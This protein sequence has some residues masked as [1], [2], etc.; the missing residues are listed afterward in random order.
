M[1]V[2]SLTVAPTDSA[3]Q[4]L[5]NAKPVGWFAPKHDLSR[6]GR[7]KID[8]STFVLLIPTRPS[9]SFFPSS[10]SY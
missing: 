3:L 5:T 9:R 2:A 6:S 1:A 10:P 4:E 7:T 8:E